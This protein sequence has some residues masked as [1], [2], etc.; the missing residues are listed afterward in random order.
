M[1]F[2]PAVDIYIAPDKHME[3][4]DTIIGLPRSANRLT[5]ALGLQCANWPQRDVTRGMWSNH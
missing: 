3:I 4:V 2:D 1:I 5:T